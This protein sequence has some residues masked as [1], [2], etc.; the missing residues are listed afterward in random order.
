M[1]TTVLLMAATAQ[2]CP[3]GMTLLARFA[4]SGVGWVACEDF[5]TPTGGIALVPADGTPTVWLSKSLEKYE[6][7]PDDN[8]YL[9]LGKRA[10]LNAQHRADVLG[11]ALLTCNH[12]TSPRTSCFSWA[13]T[14]FDMH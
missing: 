8:Y 10:A 13:E 9:G 7:H 2:S 5:S 4:E 3:G 11:A 6:E 1:M 14:Q 12:S